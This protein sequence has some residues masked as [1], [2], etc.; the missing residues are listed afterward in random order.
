MITMTAEIEI[1]KGE[2]FNNVIL[3]VVD[4]DGNDVA[5]NISSDIS[6]I[7]SRIKPNTVRGN[8]FVIGS[9]ILGGGATFSN[10]EDYFISKYVSSNT[11]D[12]ENNTYPFDKD[13][14]INLESNGYVLGVLPTIFTI[15]FDY[16]N[17]IYPSK[18]IIN[19]YNDS[20]VIQWT[21]TY[22]PE[23]PYFTVANLDNSNCVRYEII[24]SGLNKPNSPLV[25]LG[26][27][28][29]LSIYADRRNLLS[30][31]SDIKDRSDN[32]QPSYGIISNGGNLS[33]IDSTGE[34]K[35]Y[36]ELGLL[37]SDLPVTLWL[38]DTLTKKEEI[39]GVFETENWEYN[40]LNFEV[41]I[42]L[43]DNL[44][45]LQNININP[46]QYAGFSLTIYDIFMWIITEMEK[47][48]EI[49]FVFCLDTQTEQLF[50]KTICAYP[51]LNQGNLWEQFTKICNITGAN[52]YV[53]SQNKKN[54]IIHTDFNGGINGNNYNIF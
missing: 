44:E 33:M 32:G 36:A 6:N 39:I 18:I 8:P 49:P 26:I 15:L 43:K 16:S 30:L 10:G 47:I 1:Y 4:S 9:S 54:I 28:S 53:S 13:I 50:K 51:Y 2:S 21:N 7:V 11:I 12:V 34:I 27:Y 19:G 45:E 29:Q 25:L 46:L 24:I 48:V 35:A 14:I 17:N 42:T 3:S 31:D 38:K 40:T 22:L 37:T 52:I 20:D 5:N 23:T 41:N